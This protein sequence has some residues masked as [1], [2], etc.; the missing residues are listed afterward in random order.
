MNF[1]SY[2]CL[3]PVIGG[4]VLAAALACVAQAATGFYGYQ[5]APVSFVSGYDE[6]PITWSVALFSPTA[7]LHGYRFKLSPSCERASFLNQTLTFNS[8]YLQ[9][10]REKKTLV[11][12]TVDVPAYL[13]YR[14]E[15]KVEER[16]SS[17][18]TRSITRPDQ[19]RRSGG[20]GISVG[21]PKRL[22]KIFGEG[23]AGLRVSGFRKIMFSGRSQ[24]TDGAESDLYRQSKFPSL[25]MEQ[26]YRFDIN[27]TIGSKIFVKVSEDSQQDIPLANRLIIRYKGDEDDI[28]KSIEAGNTTLS[29]P[30]TRFV[31]YSQSIRGLFGVKAEAQVG[32]LTLIGIASQEQGSS[33]RVS[34]SPTGEEDAKYLRDYE[35][36]EGRIF[37]LGYP[38]EFDPGDSVIKLFVYEGIDKR[39]ETEDWLAA[40]LAV[41][42]KSPGRFLG[43]DADYRNDSK[44]AVRQIDQTQYLFFSEPQNRKHYV[45]FNSNR[46]PGRVVGIYME[47]LKADGDT[48][49]VGELETPLLLKLIYPASPNPDL[50]TWGLMWRNCYN[51]PTGVNAEDIDI[52]VFKGS[53]G[54]EG[55][56][57]TFEFQEQ[58][59]RTQ[60]LIEILGLDQYTDA[61]GE[62]VPDGRFD[63]RPEVFRPEW[64]LIIFPHRRPF[65]NEPA[66]VDARGNETIDLVP[67]VTKIYSYTSPTDKTDA[68]Q[69]Y[70]QK[71]TKARSKSI[72]L[73]RPNIIEG[74]ERV[75]VNGRPL[76]KGTDYTINYDF[77]QIEITADEYQNDPNAD[78]DIQFEY[79]PFFAVQ[80]KTLL[81]MRAEYVW[82]KDLEFGTTF[83]Y[84]SDKAEDRKPRVGQET[85]RAMVYALDGSWRTQAKFITNLVDA[86]PL[87]ETETPST[88]RIE[89]EL[90]QSL[91]NPNVDNVAYV[92]D[93]EAAQDQ[94]SLGLQ[95]TTWKQASI[96][97]TIDT[98]LVG[99]GKLL[100]HAPSKARDVTEIWDI[101]PKQGEGTIRTLRLVFRPDQTA[102][103]TWAG[104]MRG[105]ANRIDAKRLQLL[106][107]RAR[108]NNNARGKLHIDIGQIN[109]DVTN[110][111]QP[112]TEDSK[113]SNSALE[114]EEDVGLDG[115]ADVDEPGY[116][117][118]TLP[119]PSG[120]NWFFLGAGKCPLPS[121][122]C[123][124][125]INEK[126]WE[127]NDSIYYEWLNGTEGNRSDLSWLGIP[128][129]ECLN[130]GGF[131]AFD[132]YFSYVIDFAHLDSFRV[133]ESDKN[134][135]WT[136]RIPVRDS[137]AIDTIITTLSPD[138]PLEPDWDAVYHVRVWFESEPGQVQNDTVEIAAWY[139]V[140]SNWQD[141]VVYGPNPDSTSFFVASVSEEDKTFRPPPGVEPYKDPNYNT[142]EAQR[143]L[144]LKFD[145][146]DGDDTCIARKDLFEAD[147]YTGYRN[148]EMYVYGG[149]DPVQAEQIQFFFRLGTSADNFYEQRRPVYHGWDERNHISFDFND[150]TALK[151]AALKGRTRL[152]YGEIDTLSADGVYRVRGNPNINDIRF[153][154]AGIVNLDSVNAISGELWLDELRVTEVRRDVGTAG[155][156]AFNGTIADLGSYNFSY[157]STDAFFRG[158]SSTT[159]GGSAQNLGS[160]RTT[161]RIS[162]GGS[163]NLDRFLPRSL[164]ARLPVSVSQSKSTETPL[165]RTS[166]DIVLPEETRRK[167]RSVSESGSLN[168]SESFSRQGRNPL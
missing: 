141:S 137:A 164:G 55:T 102:G 35:Y 18:V 156:V 143:G 139:F 15:K 120:D 64:G 106:E 93:F 43:E 167:E 138:G 29:L 69:Y 130:R 168:I 4:L 48:A 103:V 150:L 39:Q 161:T 12:V 142:T 132:A 119:D 9:R 24:W 20:L 116:D 16:F 144:L 115:L 11:P 36:E 47:I 73:G 78:V 94:L 101:D 80:K 3:Q 90:A 46:R 21:L 125:I 154:E 129:D 68:S 45:V 99:R 96:P 42:P 31:G 108:V 131:Q 81:G 97:A 121:D 105:F 63:E 166:S 85:A 50:R 52:K 124:E 165:L 49:I 5:P 100:W 151:D 67:N 135:W 74:S 10:G 66:S 37:D 8:T 86:L 155:R 133:E 88:F 76:Q 149:I 13:A 140:Q 118:D 1:T 65:A 71:V 6:P 53:R 95:R 128:D 162:Y 160:G 157:E 17:L 91:P 109:E 62:K 92:D 77:G 163:V 127:N 44:N 123:R 23:G 57:N 28:L 111:G 158:L 2:K 98:N 114:E 51:I 34:I 159:R 147:Q 145:D 146:L 110:D 104:T 72:R 89:G 122:Q 112:N 59:G 19:Q 56:A 75:T 84:K 79:A 83:L 38:E 148:L 30:R 33:E 152:E 41:D 27:G 134:D 26:I 126:L 82:S 87:V 58:E 113:F 40:F 54:N 153:F 25:S 7:D 70:I 107:L 61:T 14:K 32:R 22:N 136:Y 60:R 117:P